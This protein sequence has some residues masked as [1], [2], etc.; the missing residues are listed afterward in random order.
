MEAR[1]RLF[2]DAL[3]LRELLVVEHVRMPTLLA[4]VLRERVASPEVAKPRVLLQAR[5]R[6]HGARI[7]LTRRVRLALAPAVARAHLVDRL[8]VVVVL[9]RKVLAPDGRV[10]DGVVERDHAVERRSRLLLPSE[11]VREKR[12]DADDRER[13]P[14]DDEDQPSG[15]KTRARRLGRGGG[16]RVAHGVILERDDQR[17]LGVARRVP[18][19]DP[20]SDV[21]MASNAGDRL[22]GARR[23]L[24]QCNAERLPCSCPRR[25]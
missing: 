19:S 16:M 2:R 24:R 21:R 12:R 22:A 14:K 10:V 5:L 7:R 11:D 15:S 20:V 23:C 18:S 3:P 1:S 8:P 9:Q 13:A 6:D 4:E 17:S 25:L